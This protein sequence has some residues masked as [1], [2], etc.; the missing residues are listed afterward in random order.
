MTNIISVQVDKYGQIKNDLPVVYVYGS[1]MQGE[2]YI[3]T[4]ENLQEALLVMEG[5]A[6]K[7]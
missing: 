3:Y 6:P 1:N 2:I 5:E 4:V 7:C